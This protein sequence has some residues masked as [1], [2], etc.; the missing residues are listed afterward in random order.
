MKKL[1]ITD[2][3]GVL[4][5]LIRAKRKLEQWLEPNMDKL[6]HIGDQDKVVELDTDK[7]LSMD[8]LQYIYLSPEKAILQIMYFYGVEEGRQSWKKSINMDLYHLAKQKLCSGNIAYG[9]RLLEVACEGKQ[10]HFT[11]EE[12][13]KFQKLE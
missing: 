4:T 6:Y 12:L 11:E 5:E 9:I 8:H 13:T 7:F 10:F 1:P 2:F 3:D